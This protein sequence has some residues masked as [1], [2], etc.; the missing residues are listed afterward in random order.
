MPSVSGKQH[1]FMEAVAH[2]WQPSGR[3]VD[4]GVAKEYSAADK[5]KHFAAYAEGGFVGSDRP[6][7]MGRVHLPRVPT[8]KPAFMRTNYDY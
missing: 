5:G 2:G 3:H 7:L 4:V 6:H 8:L 1:R